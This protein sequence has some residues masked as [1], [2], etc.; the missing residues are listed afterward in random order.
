MIPR[1][2]RNFIFKFF[3]FCLVVYALSTLKGEEHKPEEMNSEVESIHVDKAVINDVEN[4]IIEDGKN[5]L[6]LD[7]GQN[8]II[9]NNKVPE[10]KPFEKDINIKEDI[11]NSENKAK[12]KRRTQIEGWEG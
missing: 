3:F 4:N 11:V 1:R 2:S 9:N 5:V 10:L 7:N 6:E 8:N 12:K